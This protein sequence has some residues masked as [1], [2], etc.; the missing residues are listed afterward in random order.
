MQI[1][2]ALSGQRTWLLGRLILNGFAQ[3]LATIA[4]AQLVKL[5]FDKFIRH[6]PSAS[7]STIWWIGLGLAT[8]AAAIACLRALERTDA[9]RI[10]QNYASEVRI[11]LYERL[12]SLAPRA[13]Q[14]RSQGGVMLRF[15]GDLT[16][17][18]QWVSLGLARLVVAIATTA[19]TLLALAWIN[20]ALAVAI[21]ATLSLGILATFKLGQQLQEKA[22]ES[23][24]RLSYLAANINEKIAAMSVVQVFG[25]TRREKKRIVRQSRQLEKARTDW[26]KVAGQL[27]GTAEATAVVATGITLWLGALEVA[28][29]RATPGTVVAAMSVVGLLVPS[30]RDL[31]RVQEYWHNYQ[32]AKQKMAE[33]LKTPTFVAEVPNAP[34]LKV[35]SGRLEFRA[36]TVAGVLQ[37]VSAIAEPGQVVA[38]VGSNGA[39][40]STLLSLAARLIDPDAGKIYLDGQDLATHRLSSVRRAIGMASPD[41]PL[42]RGTI[43]KNLRYRYSKASQAE[44]DRV[45]HLCDIPALLDELPHGE[46]TRISERGV[47]LS[48]GQRQRIALAR[49][50]LGSP[51]L[52]LLDEVDAN[53]DRQ[54]AQIVERVL[55]EHRGTILIVSHR[56]ERLAAADVVWHLEGGQLTVSEGM[57]AIARP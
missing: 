55:A 12:S 51:P 42:L 54:A 49:A 2:P 19:T 10:G 46:Q 26:A 52:L 41:L 45:W 31:G 35:K 9:E 40:K 47:G 28:G 4:H 43:A 53:L 57:G 34:R 3:A 32:V 6:S 18:R 17:V 22:R 13:L 50:I 24:R 39:G 15:V 36:V 30:L 20:L 44:I 25:Q 16:A 29:G 7:S 11:A 48:A 5:V 23:R 8:A 21:T 33:F 27:R 14:L 38:I 37:T 1:P 56:P